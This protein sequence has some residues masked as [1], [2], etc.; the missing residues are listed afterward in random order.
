MAFLSYF[1]TENQQMQTRRLSRTAEGSGGFGVLLMNEIMD[2]DEKKPVFGNHSEDIQT[3]LDKKLG[4]EYIS[5]RVGF[6]TSRIAYIEGWRVI[7]LANQ[8]FGYNGWSTEVKSVVIDFLMS[9]RESL[10]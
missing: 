4:P 10:A 7:N 1:A 8:I 2:M 9:D 3:K 5:K 6:G